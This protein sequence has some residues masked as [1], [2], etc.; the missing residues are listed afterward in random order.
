M[1]MVACRLPIPPLHHPL[2]N[3]PLYILTTDFTPTSFYLLLP[4]DINNQHCP[5]HS[6]ESSRCIISIFHY[7]KM[8]RL[9]SH[10]TSK[11]LQTAPKAIQPSHGNERRTSKTEQGSLEAPREQYRGAW[12][13][14]GNSI[15]E[16]G[17]A[18]GTV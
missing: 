12:R 5:T 11:V 8:H 6:I 15:E 17:D 1:A 9:C 14:H 4:T 16:P 10:G 13:R 2:P 7:F 18:T 3:L